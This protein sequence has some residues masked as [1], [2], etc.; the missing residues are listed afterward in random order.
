[1]EASGLRA[2]DSLRQIQFAKNRPTGCTREGLLMVEMKSG[3]FYGKH[4]LLRNELR[5]TGAVTDIAESMGKVT[6]VSS[7]A[8]RGFVFFLRV[9]NHLEKCCEKIYLC[10]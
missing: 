6:E 10:N 1:M 5:R 9:K 3:D 4:D 2:W 7:G 8:R